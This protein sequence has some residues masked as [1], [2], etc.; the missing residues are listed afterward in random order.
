MSN[1]SQPSRREWLLGLTL[2]VALSR[3]QDVQAAES[4][5]DA[6]ALAVIY[7]DIAEPFR[8]VFSQIVEGVSAQAHVAVH[9]FAVGAQVDI[10]S[11]NAQLRRLNV[12]GV[13]ALGRQGLKTASLL[14]RELAITVGGVI[15]LPEAEQRSFSGISLAPDPALLFEQLKALQTGVKRVWVVADLKHNDWL[16]RLAKEAARAQGLELLIQKVSTLAE[17]IKA[18]EQV[19]AS[20]DPKRDA[21]WLPHDPTAMDEQTVLPLVLREAW[22]RNV[23]VFSS[24]YVHVKKGVL[25]VLYPDN[26]ALGRSLATTALRRAGD[27]RKGLVPLRDVS[28]AVN[29]RTANHLGLSIS[30]EQQRSFDAVFP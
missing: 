8:S 28:V 19:Y 18:H 5:P 21:A 12:K 7:P 4:L 10:A 22:Q 29:L 20:A 15:S 14:E 2:G 25:F 30:T 27:A 16:M 24:S 13:I 26:Q 3:L 23:A 6:A 11:L 17:A 1:F 9:A